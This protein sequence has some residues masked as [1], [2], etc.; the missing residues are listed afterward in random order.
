MYCRSRFLASWELRGDETLAE[1]GKEVRLSRNLVASA[2]LDTAEAR[3]GGAAQ[4]SEI[5]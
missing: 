3:A 2:L 4:P 5:A 1:H